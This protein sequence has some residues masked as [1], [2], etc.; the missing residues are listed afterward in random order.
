MHVEVVRRL[1]HTPLAHKQRV[2]ETL[3]A[4]QTR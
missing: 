1:F 4:Y 2:E 3:Q